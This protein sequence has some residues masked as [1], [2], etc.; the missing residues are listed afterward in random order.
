MSIALFD[1][2]YWK[3]ITING[4]IFIE[5][6]P[7]ELNSIVTKYKIVDENGENVDDTVYNFQLI[8]SEY[9]M[10]EYIK[11]ETKVYTRLVPIIQTFPPIPP[12]HPTSMLV[13][14]TTYIKAKK[15]KQVIEEIVIEIL[16]ERDGS[17]EK[18]LKR[19]PLQRHTYTTCVKCDT[20]FSTLNTNDSTCYNCDMIDY[21]EHFSSMQV[22][23]KIKHF[24][25][26]MQSRYLHTGWTS[27]DFFRTNLLKNRNIFE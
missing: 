25:M 15:Y 7:R 14:P 23:R 1:E 12:T 4:V 20:Y 22:Y 16:D 5:I 10:V 21:Y 6:I 27:S 18:P 3:P 9:K 13:I 8:D 26:C 2:E 24:N 11:P 17:E 19:K